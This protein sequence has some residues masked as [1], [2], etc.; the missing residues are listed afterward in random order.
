MPAT[1]PRQ[2]AHSPYFRYLEEIAP[3][4]SPG[5]THRHR[6]F[7]RTLT[8]IPARLFTEQFIRTVPGLACGII[9]FKRAEWDGDLCNFSGFYV[10]AHAFC[11]ISVQGGQ[12]DVI[13]LKR[14][15]LHGK[16]R[17]CVRPGRLYNFP[18]P[19]GNRCQ[20]RIG[21]GKCRSIRLGRNSI[22]V[23]DYAYHNYDREKCK[24]S[25]QN[26]EIPCREQIPP[27][28]LFQGARSLP[29]DGTVNFS[30]GLLQDALLYVYLLIPGGFVCYE[31]RN[32]Q[33]GGNNSANYRNNKKYQ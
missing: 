10:E 5:N 6:K 12:D 3:T 18:I 7:K 1:R 24:H 33:E 20:R 17:I 22:V 28:F 15:R 2:S 31:G 8:L 26:T 11:R 30:A 14:R 4:S 19:N 13:V 23:A 32:L 25:G 21:F 16:R 27:F 29:R 9:Y